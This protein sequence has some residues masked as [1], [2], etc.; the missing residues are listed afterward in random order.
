MKNKKIMAISILTTI[1]MITSTI[2]IGTAQKSFQ[3]DIVEVSKKVLQDGEWVKEADTFLN[4]EVRFN[5]TVEYNPWPSEDDASYIL[6]DINITDVL[7]NSCLDTISNINLNYYGNDYNL[8]EMEEKFNIIYNMNT[9]DGVVWWNLT[10]TTLPD[11]YVPQNPS[12]MISL[13]NTS[14]NYVP[15]DYPTNYHYVLMLQH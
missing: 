3:E 14:H 13:W 9:S 2:T 8:T 6:Y 10:N 11:G 4:E 12:E 5:I 7:H 15:N 1:L